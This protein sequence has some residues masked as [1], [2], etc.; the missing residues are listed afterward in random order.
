MVVDLCLLCSFP[1]IVLLCLL[2]GVLVQADINYTWGGP[3]GSTDPDP[4][5]ANGEDSQGGNPSPSRVRAE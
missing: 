4:N 3:G 1:A 5:T 2:E